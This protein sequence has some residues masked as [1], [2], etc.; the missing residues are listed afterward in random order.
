MF[1]GEKGIER[2]RIVVFERPR[3]KG[4]RYEGL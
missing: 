4:Y 2:D 1:V 3:E